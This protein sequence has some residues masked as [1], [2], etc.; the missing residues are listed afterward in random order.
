MEMNGCMWGEETMT[1]ACSQMI[2]GMPETVMVS[3]YFVN[4]VVKGSKLHG[5]SLLALAS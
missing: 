5:T 2:G 3:A 1:L 4:E